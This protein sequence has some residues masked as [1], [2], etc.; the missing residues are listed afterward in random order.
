M[1][2]I[3]TVRGVA[4]FLGEG[5]GGVLQSP[6]HR[7]VNAN[8]EGLEA[9]EIAGGIEQAIDGFRIGAGG[10]GKTDDGAIGVGHDT[11]RVV[12]IIEEARSLAAEWCVEFAGEGIRVRLRSA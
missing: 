4:D 1:A 2:L 12:R 8:I 10:F 11:N 7:R 5:V 6:H 9:I 3:L